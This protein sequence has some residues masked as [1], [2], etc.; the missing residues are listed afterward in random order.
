MG[1]RFSKRCTRSVLA[2]APTG[3]WVLDLKTVFLREGTVLRMLNVSE[4]TTG[5]DSGHDQVYLEQC[6]LQSSQRD[7]PHPDSRTRQIK[8]K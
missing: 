3:S 2:P 8:S 5:W 6:L 4:G 7:Q 1:K